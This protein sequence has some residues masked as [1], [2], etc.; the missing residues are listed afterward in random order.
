MQTTKKTYNVSLSWTSQ[1]SNFCAFL[2]KG[3]FKFNVS[4]VDPKYF[5]ILNQSPT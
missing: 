1:N 3:V 5:E 4:F 2:W